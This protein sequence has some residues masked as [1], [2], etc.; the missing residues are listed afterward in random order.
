MPPPRFR[1]ID[2]PAAD[3]AL[4]LIRLGLFVL[5]FAVPLSAVVS[6]R[7]VFTLLPIG[8]GLLLLAATLQTRVPVAR[9]VARG[10]STRGC[11]G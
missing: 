11:A 1:P 6:R 4:L 2:D 7:A 3:A 5:A 9:R 10:L 8:A